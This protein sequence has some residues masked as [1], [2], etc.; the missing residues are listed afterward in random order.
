MPI[1]RSR[2]LSERFAPRYLLRARGERNG[3]HEPSSLLARS[4]YLRE[5]NREPRVYG[6]VGDLE[7]RMAS[8]VKDVRL[9][10]RMRFDVFYREMA[11]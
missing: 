6:R 3:S 10:Q 7:V 11:A 1:D 8:G 9:A 2:T 4:T 5:R